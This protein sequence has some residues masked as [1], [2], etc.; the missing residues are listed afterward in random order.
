MTRNEFLAELKKNLQSLAEAEQEEALRYYEEYF[1]DAGPENEERVIEEL[2]SP[3]ELARNIIANSTFSLTRASGQ[4]EE[5]HSSEQQRFRQMGPAVPKKSSGESKALFWIL[6]ILTSIIWVPILFGVVMVILGLLFAVLM[7]AVGLAIACIALLICAFVALFVGVPL[8]VTS[9]PDGL[10]L[11]GMA[12]QYFG[13]LMLMGA[14]TILCIKYLIP[15]AW[16]QC[17]R[18]FQFLGKKCRELM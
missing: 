6:V 8:V 17:K 9:A 1:D 15:W 10:L 18:F 4:Q 2:G 14:L 5:K 3:A 7:T 12:L 13:G 16:K 11:I